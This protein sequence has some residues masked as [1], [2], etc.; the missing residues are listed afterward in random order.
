M[1]VFFV[2]NDNIHHNISSFSCKLDP[3]SECR[4]QVDFGGEA[5]LRDNEV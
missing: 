2:I 4:R 1:F 3:K 5:C